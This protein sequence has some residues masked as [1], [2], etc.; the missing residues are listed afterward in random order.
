M[1]D[2]AGS[3]P[4]SDGG[5]EEAPGGPAPGESMPGVQAEAELRTF[6]I[7]D[8]RGYTTYTGDH[9]A[10]A[11]A[12]LAGRFAAIVREVV[13]AH[14]G[15]LLELRGDEAL[16]VFVLARRAL[17]SALELQAR[18]AAELPRGVGIGLDAGEAIPVE[19]GYR[20]S[21]LNLAARLCSQAG[22]GETLAS[23]AVIHLAAK[24]DG[25][26]Y[27]DPRTFR[28]KG[29]DEPIR[30]VH[31]V[32]A[33]QGSKK[34]IRYGGDR[35][36][37]RR[38]LAAGGVGLAAVALIVVAIIATRSGGLTGP[39][40]TSPGSQ[41]TIAPAA[42][43]PSATDASFPNA[44]EKALLADIAAVPDVTPDT[45]SRDPE[46]PFGFVGVMTAGV[47][48][49]TDVATGASE[50]VVRRFATDFLDRHSLS[51]WIRVEVGHQGRDDAL[52]EGDCAKRSPAIGSWGQAGEERGVL[53]CGV[54]DATGDALM[55][56]ADDFS[57]LL[58]SARNPRGD[59]E[60]LYRF[61]ERNARFVAP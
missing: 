55:V 8:I 59:A 31:V 18:F 10:D 56:W 50:I 47:S 14:D 13:T 20:G 40:A 34:P 28:L 11:A 35:R 38:L 46:S 21:A 7:A 12:E 3:A 27:T 6:L 42:A 44:A 58:M 19:G 17:R 43:A 53:A 9:G 24:V 5:P 33:S 48:C 22:P 60:A 37:D 25:V 41:A 61:F 16:A 26:G 30:A 52:P 57:G 2:V 51:T 1:T 4:G 49:P 15:F 45:C 39:P 54:D 29:I 32:P 36:A 23:E